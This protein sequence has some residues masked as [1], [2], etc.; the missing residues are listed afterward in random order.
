MKKKKNSSTRNSRSD[1][2]RKRRDLLKNISSQLRF[3]TAKN[4]DLQIGRRIFHFTMG[5]LVVLIYHL[6]LSREQMVSL[7]GISAGLLYLF[8]QIRVSYPEL[9]KYLHVINHFLLRAE[10]Q[11]KESSA[12]PY[13][14]A[15]L[16][17]MISFPK[18]I[19]LISILTLASADPAS[20][21][22]LSP[23]NHPDGEL[24]GGLGSSHRERPGDG[25]GSVAHLRS[26]R[27]LLALRTATRR[28]LMNDSG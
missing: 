21:G 19:A 22:A 20:A 10:E 12:V 8:E 2:L 14:I 27:C 11:L 28:A 26:T 7:L 9:S 16:I 1:K 23:G 17:S 15:L 5:L 18:A 4:S 25:R 13:S 24:T 6:L 3:P